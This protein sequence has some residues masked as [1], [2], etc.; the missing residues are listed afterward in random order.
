[1]RTALSSPALAGPL[2]RRSQSRLALALLVAV[3]LLFT[4]PAFTGKARFPV[5]FAGPAPGH[6]GKPQVNAELGDAFYAFYPWHSYL[7]DQLRDLEL[8]LWDPYRFAGT[9]FSAAIG[10]GTFY[11]PNWLYASG[12]VLAT[13]TAIALASLLASLLLSYWFLCVVRLHPYA[14]AVGAVVWTFSAFLMKWSTNEHVFGSALWL[15]LALGGLEVARRGQ[16]RRGVTLATLGLALSLLAGHAQVALIV[17]L[18][19]ALWAGVSIVFTRAGRD[20]AGGAGVGRQIGAAVA[21]FGL[22]GGIAAIQLLPTA[23]FTSLI[24]RQ[25]T[26][27]E[28]AKRTALPEAHAPTIVLPDYRGSPL[29][30]NYAGP[31]VNYTETALYAGIFTLPLALLGL[32]N[33][34]GR[35]AVYVLLLTVI[36]LL[37]TFGTP[38]YRLVLA[39]PGFDRTLFVTR[40]I[41][42]VDVGLAGLAAVGV[43]SLLT[44]PAR[45]SL[46]LLVI[47]L[48]AVVAVLV[49]LTVD[50]GRTPLPEAYIRLR[51]VR[52]VALV[53]LGGAAI[54]WLAL[55]P[56]RVPLVGL[57]VLAIVTLDLWRFAFPYSP[58]QR[59]RDVYA[60]SPVVQYLAAV[61]GPRPR[62][63]NV[64]V[65]SV[66][67]N[68]ALEYGIY[69]IE[70]YDPFV[71]KRIVELVSIA[72][73]QIT[74]ASFN[75][76]GPFQHTAFQSPVMDLL[77][78]RSAVAP[79]GTPGVAAGNSVVVDR[80]SAFPPAFLTSCWE[81]VDDA[82][83]LDRLRGMTSAQLRTTAIVSRGDLPAVG[84]G[85]CRNAGDATIERYE[86]ERV[87]ARTRADAASVLVLTDAWFPGWTVTVDGKDATMLLVDHA[88]RGVALPAG[89]HTVQFR[90]RPRALTAGAGVT[91]VSL[92]FLVAWALVSRRRPGAARPGRIDVI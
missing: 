13:F 9:A 24:L 81:H 27:F 49:L 47:P 34:P 46:G 31:G 75:F 78:V 68:G 88:L 18:A 74:K 59:P 53:L 65:Y 87:V 57:A 5:D 11:P 25:E 32:L 84:T 90:F 2:D 71:P 48:L 42:L 35:L 79:A 52:A 23:Q 54:A 69:G 20:G 55:Q 62:Y 63:A 64:G 14:A 36:G 58:Y 1:M 80:P 72:E 12:H 89:E 3:W 50:H 66:A 39:L 6:E 44:E 22:A 7:G 43:H 73:D 29:D 77:G 86:P 21:A 37:A 30:R 91:G 70:G 67:P 83:A 56:G 51:G 19:V 4:F 15:P 40:F 33:R 28:L 26:T 76:F 41:L 45:R 17:W 85:P 8:P 10:T 60:R 82:A 16:F 61:Q 92:L 38:F